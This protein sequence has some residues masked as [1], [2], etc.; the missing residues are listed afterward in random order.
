M[1][2]D[3]VGNLFVE[4]RELALGDPLFGIEEAIR[5]GESNPGNLHLV[6]IR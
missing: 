2:Q 3:P 5:I 4:Q 1:G 6:I